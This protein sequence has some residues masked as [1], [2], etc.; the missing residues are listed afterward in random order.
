[1][2]FIDKH[3]IV[4]SNEKRGVAYAI[5]AELVKYCPSYLL[6]ACLSK[7]VV[8][9]ITNACGNKKHILHS[10]AESTIKSIVASAGIKYL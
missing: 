7:R 3:L 8:R 6:P 4:P 10:I 5:V 1:M 9:S 2:S